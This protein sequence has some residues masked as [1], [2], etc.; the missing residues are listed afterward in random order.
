[1]NALEAL[2]AKSRDKR[3]PIEQCIV[4]AATLEE[5]ER[6]GEV[7]LMEQAANDLRMMDAQ[8]N[9]LIIVN[10]ELH[11][12]MKAAVDALKDMLPLMYAAFSGDLDEIEKIPLVANARGIV[13]EYESR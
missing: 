5:A 3:T 6:D 7:E 11:E 1:M 9:S 2:R 8:M 13:L 10:D 12:K 4:D